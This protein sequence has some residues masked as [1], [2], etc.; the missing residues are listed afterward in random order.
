L[1]KHE[2]VQSFIGGPPCVILQPS[3]FA[4]A[5]FDLENPRMCSNAKKRN[6]LFYNMI[7]K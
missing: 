5:V 1:D 4:M 6:I 2:L 7:D 3:D